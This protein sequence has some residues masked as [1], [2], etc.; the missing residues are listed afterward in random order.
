MHCHSAVLA[1]LFAFAV[2][3]HTMY[4]FKEFKSHL[5]HSVWLRLVDHG[6]VKLN[7]V[8]GNIKIRKGG[9]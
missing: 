8:V 6:T 4:I 3:R 7:H 2:R 1:V 5:V 9:L